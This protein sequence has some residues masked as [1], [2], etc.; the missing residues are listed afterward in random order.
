MAEERSPL[1]KCPVSLCL[2]VPPENRKESKM[3]S[4][5]IADSQFIPGGPPVPVVLVYHSRQPAPSRDETA[6][7]RGATR[8]TARRPVGGEPQP[9]AA[10]GHARVRRTSHTGVAFGLGSPLPTLRRTFT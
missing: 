2:S 6:T 4:G 1:S 8:A 5:P 9:A 10:L 7:E 3:N